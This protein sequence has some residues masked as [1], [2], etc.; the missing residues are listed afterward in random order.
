MQEWIEVEDRLPKS[1]AAIYFIVRETGERHI[2]KMF[3]LSDCFWSHECQKFYS[4]QEVSHWILRAL[5]AP[6]EGQGAE[7]K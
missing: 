4:P 3:D 5:P 1:N 7:K 2:G 6:P